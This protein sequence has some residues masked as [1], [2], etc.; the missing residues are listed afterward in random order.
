M[1]HKQESWGWGCEI[2]QEQVFFSLLYRSL[3][4]TGPHLASCAASTMGFFT[5]SEVAGHVSDHLPPYGAE[6]ENVWK[7]T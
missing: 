2:R 1:Q 4:G 3:T 5:G 6:S 7:C